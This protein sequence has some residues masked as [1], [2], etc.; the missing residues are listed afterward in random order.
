MSAEIKTLPG[1]I[2]LDLQEQGDVDLCLKNAMDAGL[3]DVVIVG[4]AISGEVIVWGSQT[5]ADCVIGLLTR[6]VTFLANAEQGEP[7]VEA[8]PE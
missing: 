2:R 7:A 6:G 1:V 4:R 8:A 5:D 3:R